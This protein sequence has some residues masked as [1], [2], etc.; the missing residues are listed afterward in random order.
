VEVDELA[1]TSVPGVYAAGDMAHRAALPMPFAA[2]SW[3]SA[4]GTLASAM[5][6]QDLIGTDFELPAPAHQSPPAASTGQDSSELTAADA[7]S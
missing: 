6:D 7:M 1:R 2:V 4:S 3:A 5:L